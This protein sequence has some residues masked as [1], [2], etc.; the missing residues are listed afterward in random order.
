M[1]R[2]ASITRSAHI[3]ANDSLSPPQRPA[4]T[5]LPDTRLLLVIKEILWLLQ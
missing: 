1:A 2:Q 4:Q 5:A 3:Y